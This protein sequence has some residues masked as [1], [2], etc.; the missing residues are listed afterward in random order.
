MFLFGN[1]FILL[2]HDKNILIFVV[3]SL[4]L[5]QTHSR[6]K[7]SSLPK[8]WNIGIAVNL[9]DKSLYDKTIHVGSFKMALFSLFLKSEKIIFRHECVYSTGVNKKI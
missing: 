2:S 8:T 7:K 1:Y 3:V 9:F 6:K 4:N 5:Y